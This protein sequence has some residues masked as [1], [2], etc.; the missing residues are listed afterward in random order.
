MDITPL[1]IKDNISHLRAIFPAWSPTP[2]E[3]EVWSFRLALYDQSDVRWAIAEHKATS[4]DIWPN[5]AR[6]IGLCCEA[7]AARPKPQE[8]DNPEYESTRQWIDRTLAGATPELLA[9]IDREMPLAK[10]CR[11]VL[12]VAVEKRQKQ[13]R[14]Y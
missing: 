3:L 12:A 1:T 9:E 11:G 13:R 8:E 5:L 6:V 14:G 4:T 10:F 7:A 2:D